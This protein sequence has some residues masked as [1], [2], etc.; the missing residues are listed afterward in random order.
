ML[1]LSV[2]EVMVGASAADIRLRSALP[3]R[4]EQIP[5]RDLS[6]Q[7][8]A[9]D[10]D[11]YSG[12]ELVDESKVRGDAVGVGAGDWLRFSD[13]D[14]RSGA[15]TFT[16]RTARAEPGASTVEIRL[17]GPH[18]RLAGTARIAST[19]DKY[20]YSTTTAALSGLNGR[21]DVY[22]VFTS[23]SRISTFSLR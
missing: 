2:H 10:F 13:V 14:F 7:T 19:G 9:I 1:E 23:D 15:R 11:D 16:A 5:P 8:R 6:R 18:G 17:D 22:L 20:T 3:V 4:G 12:V 21:H